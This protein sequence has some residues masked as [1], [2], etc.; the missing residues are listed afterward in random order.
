MMTDNEEQ[1]AIT[2]QSNFASGVDAS[3]NQWCTA[4]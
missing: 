1:S 4:A 2:L 3:Y